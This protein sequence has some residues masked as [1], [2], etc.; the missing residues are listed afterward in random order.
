MSGDD[1]L[2]GSTL[3]IARHGQTEANAAGIFQGRNDTPL[4]ERGREQAALVGRTIAPYLEQHLGLRFVSSPLP[5]TR[6]TM[7]II[8]EAL[9]RPRHAYE[10]DERI[11]E[12]DLG[13]WAGLTVAEAEARDPAFHAR[14]EIDKWNIPIPGGESYAMVAARAVSFLGGLK[15]DTFAVS[16]GGFGRILRGLYE[17]LRWQDMSTMPEPQDCAFRLCRGTVGRIEP[18]FTA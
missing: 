1:L 9:G 2:N 10:T 16:H 6:A 18:D 13:E 7:E 14:R 11:I 15:T 12:M 3:Y 8:L 17:G 5:R 4:T